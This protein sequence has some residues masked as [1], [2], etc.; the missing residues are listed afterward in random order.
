[1]ILCLDIGNSHLYGGVFDNNK[2]QNSNSH[3][4]HNNSN[5]N[6]NSSSG[7]SNSSSGNSNHQ[8][9]LQFRYDSKQIGS[10]D[11]LGLFFCNLLHENNINPSKIHQ[12]GIA[13][14]VP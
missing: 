10:S 1:M 6:S 5:S 14:V 13:S 3:N 12:I 11:Q 4:H 8:L 9:R 7:N 2:N